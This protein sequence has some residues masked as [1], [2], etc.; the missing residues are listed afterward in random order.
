L[1]HVFEGLVTLDEKSQ[2]VPGLAERWDVSP[3]G[4][5]YTFHLKPGVKF[6]NG[7]D[8]TAKDVEYSFMRALHKDTRSVTAMTYLNDIVGARELSEGKVETLA[9]LKVVD[10]RTVAIT[11]G[12]PRPYFLG[13]ISYVTCSIVNREAIEANGGRV[14]EKSLTGTGPLT[15]AEYQQGALIRLAANPS[16]HGGR[17][18]LDGIERPLQI[19]PVT[20]QTTYEN[21]STHYFGVARGDV[22]R[23]K[24]DP[25]QS[26]QLREFP[27]ANF[28]YL[29]LSQKAFPPFK[30]RRVRQAFAYAINKDELVRVALAGTGVAARG[31]LPPDFPGHDPSF[32]GLPFDPQKAKKLLTEA[33]YPGGKGFPRLTIHTM[34]GG[35]ET[36]DAAQTIR[37][38][39]K[40]HLGIEVDT[41]PMEAATFLRNQNNRSM[42]LFIFGWV[43]DFPD[44]Q[45]FLSTLFHSRASENIVDYGN[46][47]VDAL[48]DRADAER[49]PA[50]RM[51]L[52]REAQTL[53]VEDAPRIPLY[54]LPAIEL[55]KPELAGIRDSIVRRLPHTTTSLTTR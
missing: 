51:A 3:D 25:V 52:Y 24:A 37:S 39:L 41:V 29:A 42:P 6:H 14:D 43:A 55:H 27:R 21:G 12:G 18:K 49:D 32:K 40:Q 4:R 22:A 36:A 38:D 48:L 16:Y 26:R 7:R 44:P 15:L 30:D 31:I 34:Q 9:G 50:K 53:I 19:D 33:G 5:V 28:L 35:Q 2:V 20:R 17:P 10:D 23:V 45:N 1:Q 11:L 46:P 13:K 47:Q 54:H 8:L